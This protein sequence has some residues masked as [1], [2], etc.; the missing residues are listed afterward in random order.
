MDEI[1]AET[2]RWMRSYFGRDPRVPDEVKEEV[3]CEHS[4]T[5]T[6]AEFSALIADAIAQIPENARASAVV[7]M[8]GDEYSVLKIT[9]RRMETPE[10][11]AENV[12]RGLARAHESS[13]R[14]RAAYEALKRK[15]GPA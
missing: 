9:Y 7:E 13:A 15:Y 1:D 5:W 11:V 10:E 3:L 4:G 14:E 6:L 2:L 12:Q 8:E